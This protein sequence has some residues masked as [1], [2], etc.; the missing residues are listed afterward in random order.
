[1]RARMTMMAAFAA[2]VLPVLPAFGH[3]SNSAYQVDKIITLKGVVKDWRWS[4]P[5][6]WLFLVVKD[7]NGREQEWALEGRAPGILGRAGWD[8]KVLQ[9]GETVTVYAS[10]A[11]AGG[12]RGIIARVTK[13]DGSVLSNAP[14][15]FD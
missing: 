13:A 15:F 6:T 3:H 10:P 7:E 2:L 1:M 12:N 14:K 8:P 9:P 11:K 5:H 4:N